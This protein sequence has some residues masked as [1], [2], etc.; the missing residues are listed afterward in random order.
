MTSSLRLAMV[1]VG[2]RKTSLRAYIIANGVKQLRD[3]FREQEGRAC[4]KR[5]DHSDVQGAP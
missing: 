2:M 5:S 4:G 3:Q 1:F